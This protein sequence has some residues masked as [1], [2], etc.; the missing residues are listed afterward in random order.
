M[1]PRPTTI[2]QYRHLS[3]R[4]AHLFPEGTKTSPE[5]KEGKDGREKREGVPLGWETIAGNCPSKSNCYR[6]NGNSL[7]KTNALKK[8]EALF[9]IHCQVYRNANITGYFQLT[10]KVFYPSQRADLDNS[11][12]VVLDCLQRA[13]AIPN[14]NKC[15]RITAE[16]YLDKEKPRIEF[17]I[18]KV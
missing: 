4:N 9:F 14:D 6:I 3:A 18:I 13:K 2:E 16:K 7:V 12:K 17:Q 15:V 10:I 1:K 8:Y 5:V 11:L